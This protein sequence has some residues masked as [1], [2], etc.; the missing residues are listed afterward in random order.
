MVAAFLG[1]TCSVS[2]MF[3]SPDVG[4]RQSSNLQQLRT[5]CLAE[6][7]ASSLLGTSSTWWVTPSCA[8]SRQ[9]CG[10]LQRLTPS[11]YCLALEEQRYKQQAI[12]HF[13]ALL[14]S[15]ARTP[16]STTPMER[17]QVSFKSAPAAWWPMTGAA[18]DQAA[19]RTAMASSLGSGDCLTVEIGHLKEYSL[20][21]S[22]RFAVSLPRSRIRG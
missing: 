13:Q 5:D 9:G 14:G 8:L 4:R 15:V 16:R 6:L 1:F 10:A 20:W 21:S 7:A 22:S 3:G 2:F 18:C 19:P 17:K 12:S 11:R